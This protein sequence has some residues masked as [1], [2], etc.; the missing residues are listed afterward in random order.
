MHTSECRRYQRKIE[1]RLEVSS[2]SGSLL[3][4][5]SERRRD[6]NVPRH[7]KVKIP[8]NRRAELHGQVV[9]EIPCRRSLHAASF[10]EGRIEWRRLRITGTASAASVLRG[11]LGLSLAQASRMRM[12]PDVAAKARNVRARA[13]MRRGGNDFFSGTP[14]ASM[15]LTTGTSFASSRR[16]NSYCCVSSSKTAS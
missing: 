6:Q 4:F 13:T 7:P 2:Q 3:R 14:G 16:A 1:R 12:V 5:G 15:T 10:L 11:S 8:G 9:A